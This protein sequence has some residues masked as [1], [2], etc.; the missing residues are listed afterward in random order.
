MIFGFAWALVRPFL[1]MI[2][3]TV[4]F[5]KLAKLPADGAPYPIMVF[6]ANFSPQRLL[7]Q[8]TA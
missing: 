1:T 7:D 6:A 2:I 4:V 3:F 8:A 5:G